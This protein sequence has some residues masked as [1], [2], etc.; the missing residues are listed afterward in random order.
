MPQH[1][2]PGSH[3]PWIPCA[4]HL[5]HNGP[6]PLFPGFFSFTSLPLTYHRLSCWSSW[7]FFWTKWR[8]K[9]KKKTTL[10]FLGSYSQHANQ[11]DRNSTLCLR[12]KKIK[13][14]YKDTM[15]EDQA[16]GLFW[17][18]SFLWLLKPG[19]AFPTSPVTP[20]RTCFGGHYYSIFIQKELGV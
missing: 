12:M 6:F 9:K 18:I 4:P 11:V 15:V 16:W 8:Q 14:E 19:F 7:C 2:C 17:L 1:S 3:V 5:T 10:C 13:S 20:T